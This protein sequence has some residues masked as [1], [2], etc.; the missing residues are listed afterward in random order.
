MLRPSRAAAHG[1]KLQR[2]VAHSV[3]R[4][5]C[6]WCWRPPLVS[7][8]RGY[9]PHDLCRSRLHVARCCNCRHRIRR[10][11]SPRL[12]RQRRRILCCTRGRC[13]NRALPYRLLHP[14][15]ARQFRWR[16]LVVGASTQDH[17]RDR[18]PFRRRTWK[19][20]QHI[21]ASRSR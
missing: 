4:R 19:G 15:K 11:R 8:S 12:R 1:M 16:Q 13:N 20:G 10:R 9:P 3:V 21:C 7:R 2:D 5:R 17:C 18:V 6:C 14:S